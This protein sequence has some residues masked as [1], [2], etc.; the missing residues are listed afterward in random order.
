[1]KW[2]DRTPIDELTDK[3]ELMTFDPD[4][5]EFTQVLRAEREG[6]TFEVVV[7]IFLD[8][9][10]VGEVVNAAVDGETV[11]ILCRYDRPLDDFNEVV[12]L[13]VVAVPNGDRRHRAVIAHT[14]YS[15]ERLKLPFG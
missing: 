9:T 5:P 2:E 4:N 3:H 11:F 7:P 14:T 13:L 6:R 8:R 15:F 12:G 10:R 1:M